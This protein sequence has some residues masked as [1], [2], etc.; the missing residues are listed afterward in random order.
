[1]SW[2]PWPFFEAAYSSSNLCC[3]CWPGGMCFAFGLLALWGLLRALPSRHGTHVVPHAFLKSARRCT[4]HGR[5]YLQRLCTPFFTEAGL[6]WPNRLCRLIAG[7]T[8]PPTAFKTARVSF[9]HAIVICEGVL[10]LSASTSV[11]PP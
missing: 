2:L 9:S 11:S 4:S 6:R 10:I 3:C 1:V 5:Q 7:S 8:L